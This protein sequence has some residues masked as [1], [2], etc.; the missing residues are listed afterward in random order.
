MFACTALALMPWLAADAEPISLAPG[1]ALEIRLGPDATADYSV[2]L[3]QGMASSVELIQRSGVV[4]LE[5]RDDSGAKLD[6]RTEAGV[7]GRI[8]APLLASSSTH[9]SV[10]VSARKG[11]TDAT[12]S[13]RLSDPHPATQIDASKSAAFDRYVEAEQLRRAN[14]RETVVTRR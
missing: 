13:L 2:T 4:D 1:N 5:L 14:Y 9:W 10:V 3:P 8:E 7:D 12:F 11:K 6:V